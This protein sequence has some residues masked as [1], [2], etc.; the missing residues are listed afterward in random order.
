M[1]VCVKD[2]LTCEKIM[3][4]FL[5]KQF[6]RLLQ[7][8]SVFFSYRCAVHLARPCVRHPLLLMSTDILDDLLRGVEESSG[9]DVEAVP[10]EAAH[11]TRQ[12]AD[13]DERLEPRPVKNIR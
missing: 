9:E 4:S 5:A 12:A 11:T 1:C 2:H 10:E 8:P 6:G 13:S 7:G 3:L